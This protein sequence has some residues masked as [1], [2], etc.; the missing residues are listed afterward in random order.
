MMIVVNMP[1]GGVQDIDEADLLWLRKAF[2]G[3]WK[4]A[5]MLQLVD[6]RIYSNES[7]NDLSTKFEQANVPLAEFLAPES[8]RTKLLVSAKRVRQVIDS[9]PIIYNDKANSVLIFPTKLRLAV[10]ETPGE[11]R[12]KLEDAGKE[13]A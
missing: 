5:T 2:D 10:R 11:A 1:G 6:D 12:K 3:E 13:V 4:G 9:D 8:N 7:M